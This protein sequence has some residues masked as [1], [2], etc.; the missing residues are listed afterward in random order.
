MGKKQGKGAKKA[1][2]LALFRTI[3]WLCDF[4]V[5]S[6]LRPKRSIF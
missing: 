6:W 2:V 4:F 5:K 3:L 1:H